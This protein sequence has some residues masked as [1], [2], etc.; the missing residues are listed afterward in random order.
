M[1]NKLN[2]SNNLRQDKMSNISY[3]VKNYYP[4][5]REQ[6][7]NIVK[8]IHTNKGKYVQNPFISSIVG[9]S[10]NSSYFNN[11]NNNLNNNINYEYNNR[12]NN[13]VNKNEYNNM[14]NYNNIDNSN[15]NFEKN[16]ISNIN[17]INNTSSFLSDNNNNNNTNNLFKYQSSN[18]YEEINSY[19]KVNNS[20]N[21]NINN[22]NIYNNYNNNPYE[23]KIN[24]EENDNKKEIYDNKVEIIP[25]EIT[26]NYDKYNQKFDT[27]KQIMEKK[28]INP[29][30]NYYN[31]NSKRLS[32]PPKTLK[33]EVC[34]NNNNPKTRNTLNNMPRARD[35]NEI[36]YNHVM[37][38]S[39]NDKLMVNSPEKD[40]KELNKKKDFD[41]LS[42][43]SFFSM[44]DNIKKNPF[45]LNNKFKFINA[46]VILIGMGLAFS[47]IHLTINYIDTIKD[48]FNSIIELLSE[49]KKIL[50]LFIS[51]ISYILYAPIHYWY[52]SIPFIVLI[53]VILY[54][55][56]RNLF[57]KR[58][59]EIIENIVKDLEKNNNSGNR[60]SISQ[61]DIFKNYVEKY[62]ISYSKFLRKYLPMLQKMR[63][64]D[65]RLVLTSVKNDNKE[66]VFWE[67][68]E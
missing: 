15:N 63:R 51:Y 3:D 40:E 12:N 24:L 37:Q 17:Q 55:I 32:Y 53:F 45:Y 28:D 29:E 52:I 59:K 30:I 47:L 26:E 33:N 21:N 54:Y 48:F 25:E 66:Y 13:Y 36:P 50:E 14:N 4:N 27:N 19:S 64:D 7:I 44:F 18:P 16:N 35:I 43:T 22:N 34:S 56:R 57:R 41:E 58:C 68:N 10:F 2:Y 49:P 23:E 1:P 6:Q 38:R 9:Q 60:A 20:I 8:P 65:H 5:S 42:T 61:E 67:L 39:P 11:S 62:G 31:K 46:L